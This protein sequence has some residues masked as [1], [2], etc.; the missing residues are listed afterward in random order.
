MHSLDRGEIERFFLL[1]ALRHTPIAQLGDLREAQ[2]A[3]RPR[4]RA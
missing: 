4:H 1:E 3:E 2:K